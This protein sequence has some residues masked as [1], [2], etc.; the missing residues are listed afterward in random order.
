MQLNLVFLEV[1]SPSASL[2][3]ALDEEQRVVVLEVLARLIA[4][5]AQP[6]S[7]A[8]VNDDDR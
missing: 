3:Q 8:E 2:W 4:Q 5:A 7:D 1:P 6:Q